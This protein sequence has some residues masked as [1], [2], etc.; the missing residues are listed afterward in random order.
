MRAYF[1]IK[2]YIQVEVSKIAKLLTKEMLGKEEVD[3]EEREHLKNYK[4]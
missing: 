2:R 3:P 1:S 4:N